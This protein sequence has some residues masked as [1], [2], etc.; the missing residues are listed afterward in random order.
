VEVE[1]LVRAAVDVGPAQLF[2]GR[3]APGGTATKHLTVRFADGLAPAG[4]NDITISHDC[5]LPLQFTWERSSGPLWR[6]AVRVKNPDRA[7]DEE[8]FSATLT[9]KFHGLPVSEIL[10][11]ILGRVGGVAA[12]PPDDEAGEPPSEEPH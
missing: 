2:L 11:P 4:P 9:L 6:L 8:P 12:T 5:E 1:L 7:G 10:V 3:L